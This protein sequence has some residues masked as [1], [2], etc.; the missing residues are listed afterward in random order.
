[1]LADVGLIE[2][3]MGNLLDNALRHTPRGGQVR[4]DMA[5]EEQ[6]VRVRVVDT[7]EG[8]DAASVG[9]VFERHFSARDPRDRTRA[10]LG[11]AIV[12]RIMALHAQEVHLL[13]QPGAGTTVEITLQR[14]DTERHSQAQQRVIAA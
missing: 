5:V 13:S 1:V 6:I 7:G 2:R 10:G 12:Q 4:I 11:L 9:R 8:I 3:V 14:A